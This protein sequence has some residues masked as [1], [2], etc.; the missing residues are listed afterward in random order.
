MI[1]ARFRAAV[2]RLPATPGVYRFRDE[3][4]RALYVGRATD[5]RHRVGS[6]W[7]DLGERAHLRRMIPQIQRVEAVS[8]DSAHEAAWFERNLLETAKPRWNRV[9]GGMEVP[10]Y[11]RL[12]TRPRAPGLSVVHLVEP[13]PDTSHFGPYLGGDRARLTLAALHRI[14]PI[15][16]TGTGL[17]GSE[18]DMARMR[19]VTPADRGWI[20]AALH[21]V[22][23]GDADANG[24]ARAA[25]DDLR[26]NAARVD[27][28]ERAA[29]I[30]AERAALDWIT[31]PQRAT[32]EGGG[33]LDAYGWS[34][35]LLVHFA[36]RAGRLSGWTL[37]TA[38]EGRARP[39]VE[40]TPTAWVEFARRNA[41]LG[42]ALALAVSG[43]A[44]DAGHNSA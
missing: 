38:T 43:R 19:G 11:V 3:R 12:D 24:R 9:R 6:Y 30:Q 16:Y 29:Q 8:C 13:A 10:V 26:E 1:E 5:L 42:A 44:S 39:E 21:A 4:G 37:R 2:G 18:R 33:D 20:A 34:D 23:T 7:A 15:A 27:G 40:R 32:I 17:T 22:L 35:G 36:I 14:L 28:F 31:S 41:E 25:L